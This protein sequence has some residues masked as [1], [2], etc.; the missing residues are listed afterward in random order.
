MGAAAAVA[1]R[2]CDTS[3]LTA[4][5]H[6]L[7][8]QFPANNR[9]S[10]VVLSPLCIHT[11]LALL[12]ASAWPGRTLN[13]ILGVFGGASCREGL[14]QDADAMAQRVLLI[15]VDGCDY[16]ECL[17]HEAQAAMAP[18][19][20]PG[21]PWHGGP[22]LRFAFGLWHDAR[23]TLKNPLPRCV[24]AGYHL[25]TRVA[26][27][28][29]RNKRINWHMHP[30]YISPASVNEDT[31]LL[32]TSFIHFA[33]NFRR[34]FVRSE[35]EVRSF[36]RLDGSAV[37]AEFMRS[38]RD[39]YVAEHDG[40]KVLKMPYTVPDI[41]NG[42]SASYIAELV[43]SDLES[44]DLP[45][46]PYPRFSLCIFLP[47]D[48][49][50]GLWS[51]EEKVLSEPG[52]VHAHLPEDRVRVGEFRVPKFNTWLDTCASVKPALRGIGIEAAFSAEE[53]D[54]MGMVAEHEGGEPF[55]VND[56]VHRASFHLGEGDR[57]SAVTR[58]SST[59]DARGGGANACLR[60]PVDFVADHP[61]AFFVVEEVTG[62]ILLAGHVLDPTSRIWG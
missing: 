1:A 21:W 4:L 32:H 57:G 48:A 37:D 20:V 54:M 18:F 52:S 6:R 61:F 59:D 9:A 46:H 43:Y 28:D 55:F 51:L 19:L 13:E 24:G 62:A 30:S 58:D 26:A 49:R 45:P 17:E 36:R 8:K 42:L 56:V 11:A 47:D 16:R 53:A 3:G 2:R 23:W 41:Y 15:D 22:R 27:L 35:N 25:S 14:V 50:D 44:D 10:N 31:R 40:F 7:V 5:S 29:F 12:A 38:S 39:Q 60:P 33:G 34:P